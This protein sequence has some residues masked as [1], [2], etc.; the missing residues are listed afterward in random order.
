MKNNNSK[1][2]KANSP[3][4]PNSHTLK[5]SCHMP[6]YWRIRHPLGINPYPSE[7]KLDVDEDRGTITPSNLFFWSLE[8]LIKILSV[9]EK[10]GFAIFDA[11]CRLDYLV[12]GRKIYIFT[13]HAYFLYLYDPYGRNP[14]TAR[15]TENNLTLYSIKLS[16]FRYI[17]EHM[18][19]HINSWANIMTRWSVKNPTTVATNKT[20]RLR[21]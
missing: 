13:Y 5:L 11:M 9:P 20:H 14:R 4:Q 19:G 15:H 18:P 10:E 17:I 1:T 12:L 7:G 8:W 2:S 6:F 21:R 3:P 16:A